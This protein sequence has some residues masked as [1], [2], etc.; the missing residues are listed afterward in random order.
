MEGFAVS[1]TISFKKNLNKQIQKILKNHMQKIIAMC[2]N[3]TIPQDKAIHQIRRRFKK[4]RALTHLL[5]NDLSESFFKKQNRIFKE[6][7]HSFSASRD[8]KVLG[9]TY[10]E[11]IRKYTLDEQTY[12]AI[13]QAIRSS[14]PPLDPDQS[15]LDIKERLQKNL[16]TLKHYKL[17]KNTKAHFLSCLKKTYQKTDKLRKTAIKK[18]SDLY[19]HEWRK[20]VNYYGFQLFM[21]D[22]KEFQEKA[23][24]LKSLAHILGDI[25]D[26]TVFK[27]FLHTLDTPLG[28]EF[29]TF[30]DKEQ[31]Q[32]KRAALKIGEDIFGNKFS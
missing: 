3:E 20:W 29:E 6:C 1:S 32:L 18:K 17:K 2:E 27:T 16:K 28:K 12:D 30:L 31:T 23:E 11:I 22:K 15:F 13:L 8:Q 4:L 26:I 9:D 7:A 10:L 5:L 21:I 24:T 25:H 14:K 19:F